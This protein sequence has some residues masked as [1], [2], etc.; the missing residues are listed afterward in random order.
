MSFNNVRDKHID[1]N[2]IIN[3]RPG[4]FKDSSQ[5]LDDLVLKIVSQLDAVGCQNVSHC[6]SSNV[7]FYDFASRRIHTYAPRTVDRSI[8]DDG[9]VVNP[10]QG[11]WRLISRDYLLWSHCDSQSKGRRFRVGFDESFNGLGGRSSESRGGQSA[12]SSFALADFGSSLI[13]MVN[14]RIGSGIGLFKN[15]I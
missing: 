8:G 2:H 3:R 10:F 15:K 1:F 5:V 12:A 4:G 9:L 14:I 7:S 13:C 11:R 6:S